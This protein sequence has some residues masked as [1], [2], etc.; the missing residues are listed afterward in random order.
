MLWNIPNT[1]TF[2]RIILIPVF[3]L[4]FFILP[5]IIGD[6]WASRITFAVFWVAAV[7]DYWDGFLARKLNQTSQFGAFLDPVADKLMVVFALV[8]LTTRNNEAIFVI[9]AAIII[10]R[11]IT[12]S[13]LREWMAEYGKRGKVAVSNVGKIKTL[14]QMLS[15]MFLLYN[16]PLLG[17]S[18]ETINT[19][20]MVLFYI[21][22]ALT[23]YSMCIYLKAALSEKVIES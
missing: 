11:E 3:L 16:S 23:I 20:G 4:A 12:I 1:L 22:A 13:A 14:V 15:I 7:T 19:I 18:K 2:I 21:A 6:P 17:A 8:C 5:E 10:G 9:P